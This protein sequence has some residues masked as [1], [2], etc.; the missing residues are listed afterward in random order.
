MSQIQTVHR[1]KGELVPVCLRDHQGQSQKVNEF[2]GRL[3]IKWDTLRKFQFQGVPNLNQVSYG[4][5]TR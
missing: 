1:D 4:Q 3:N 5:G 2:K